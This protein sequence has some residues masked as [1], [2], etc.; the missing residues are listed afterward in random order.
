VVA[1]YRVRGN[2]GVWLAAAS[3]L[4]LAK[5]RARLLL[6]LMEQQPSSWLLAWL[7]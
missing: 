1:E 7:L 5:G 2:T 6:P 3:L 4:L